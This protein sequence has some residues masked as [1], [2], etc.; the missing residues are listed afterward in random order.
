MIPELQ[1][2]LLLRNRPRPPGLRLR[3]GLSGEHGPGA[4]RAWDPGALPRP[5]FLAEHC[6]P[7][8]LYPRL[9]PWGFTD[10]MDPAGVSAPF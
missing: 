9:S 8:L 5:L 2:P 4:G 6:K 3:P 1:N 10:S 7:D